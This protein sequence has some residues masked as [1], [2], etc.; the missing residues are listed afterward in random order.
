VKKFLNT[1]ETARKIK[2]TNATVVNYIKRGY[3]QGHKPYSRWLVDY[4]SIKRYLQRMQK[5]KDKDPK[6][7]LELIEKVRLR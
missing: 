6:E 7:F 4:D 5:K 3:L 1:S 2:C